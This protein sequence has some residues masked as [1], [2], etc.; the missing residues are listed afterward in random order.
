MLVSHTTH[1][2][3]VSGQ[4]TVQKSYIVHCI[5]ASR[6]PPCTRD[7]ECTYRAARNGTFAGSGTLLMGGLRDVLRVE[8]DKAAAAVLTIP[9]E[10]QQVAVVLCVGAC[11]VQ[12]IHKMWIRMTRHAPILLCMMCINPQRLVSQTLKARVSY[13]RRA[14]GRTPPL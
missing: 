8:H 5:F 6:P 3:D 13:Q 1:V 10:G 9:Q 2:H 14:W 12:R 4:A 7:P 11:S